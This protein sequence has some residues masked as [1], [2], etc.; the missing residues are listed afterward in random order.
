M[1]ANHCY[2]MSLEGNDKL[3][4]EALAAALTDAGH[5]MYRRLL[6]LALANRRKPQNPTIRLGP[7]LFQY[8]MLVRIRPTEYSPL[9]LERN[10]HWLP[11][12]PDPESGAD[13]EPSVHYARLCLGPDE[14]TDDEIDYLLRS[15]V[16][17]S[18][19][20][21]TND[22]MSRMLKALPPA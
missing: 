15:P 18:L 14:G 5:D 1:S 6:R 19:V 13:N 3:E 9:L 2:F 17:W 8:A 7:R 11:L 10:F 20:R 12:R 21:M 16:A 22:E 4:L